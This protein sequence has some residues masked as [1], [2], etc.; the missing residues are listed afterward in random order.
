VL[1]VIAVA[2]VA[3]IG[4]IAYHAAPTELLAKPHPFVKNGEFSAA[5]G[6]GTNAQLPGRG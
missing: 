6:A 2:L 5:G 3:A 1:A 4:V